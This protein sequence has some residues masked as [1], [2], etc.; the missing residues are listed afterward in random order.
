MILP[1]VIRIFFAIDLPASAK[2]KWG[3][4]V[5]RIDQKTKKLSIR[6]MKAENLHITLQF[7]PAVHTAHVSQIVHAVRMELSKAQ[8]FTLRCGKLHLFPSSFH[9]RIIALNIE[10][11]DELMNMAKLIGSGIIACHYV[12]ENR[13]FRAHV[14]LGRIKYPQKMN[15]DFLAEWI[16]SYQE[17]FVVRE[18]VLFR[19]EPTRE[20]SSYT[21]IERFALS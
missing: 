7:L 6:W 18:V 2:E 1:S 13:P 3:E 12:I 20:G 11:Q 9:P 15:I 21:A 19:S 17:T 8:S 16:V 5:T 10:P 4:F 14:T